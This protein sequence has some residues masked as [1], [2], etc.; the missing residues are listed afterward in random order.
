MPPVG[1]V[2]GRQSRRGRA[3][4]FAAAVVL[5]VVCAEVLGAVGVGRDLRVI[6]VATLVACL[7]L[8]P[9]HPR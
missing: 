5:G 7:L 3:V 2:L 6:P 1:D 4:R 9:R 8:L